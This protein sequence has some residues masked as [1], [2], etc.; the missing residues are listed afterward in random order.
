MRPPQITD[1][2]LRRK[3][4]AYLR[5]SSEDQIR[6][7]IGS[8]AIQR[9]LPLVLRGWGWPPALIEVVDT[10]LG[11]SGSIPGHREGFS[12]VL[13][14]M[15]AGLVGLVA[16]TENSRLTRNL[17]DLAAF[18]ELARRHDVLLA[19]GEAVTDFR[20]PNAAFIGA[21]L[22]ANAAREN[23]A[24]A[25]LFK[26][27]RRKKAEAG[28]AVSR[29]PVGY[30]R[31]NRLWIKDPDP[32]IQE[33]I[34]LVFDKYLELRSAGAVTRF[35]RLH[36]ILLPTRLRREGRTWVP[37][38][39]TPI[40][41]ILTHP[42]YSGAYTYGVT[43]EVPAAPGRKARWRHIWRGECPQIRVANCHE[44][45]IQP[46]VWEQIQEQLAASR[47]SLSSPAGRGEALLPGL[48][49]C[50][51]HQWALRTTYHNRVRCPDG[52]IKRVPS[53][54]CYT[55]FQTTGVSETCGKMRARRIDALVEAQILE[56]LVP[57]SVGVLEH[58]RREAMRE[59][60][61]RR[62]AREDDI[63]RAEQAVDEAE[64][65]FDQVRASQV[66]LK[67]RLGERL[68]AAL[69][70]LTD[71]RASQQARPLHPPLTLDETELAELR[72]L[73]EDLGTLWQ[74]P[75]VTFQ[76]RR[77]VV[78]LIIKAVYVT[79][80]RDR[81]T[82]EIDWVGGARTRLALMTREGVRSELRRLCAQPLSIPEITE[83]LAKKGI[84]K[85]WGPGSGQ[86]Y[87]VRMVRSFIARR[88]RGR[89]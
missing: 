41:L 74:H 51:R 53:Y 67:K 56:T 43:K 65:A 22:G 8:T 33:V 68:D 7:N 87:T 27:A 49:R 46:A 79:P 36:G 31:Q 45:Y 5:Q 16:V 13:E 3:A 75:S 77:A 55:K 86:P 15:R 54:E 64:R 47:S 63:R 23:R 32:R 84:V 69:Q 42:A 59:Y 60:D 34:Q 10:D 37:A 28:I 14:Q 6:E 73:L 30:V 50:T 88:A 12:Y 81:W 83:R 78:R 58:A 4:I 70:R 52:T 66:H 29:P 18:D 17:Q 40:F 25:L 11:V 72:G 35:F 89:A 20:D 44:P 57:P 48:V 21:I 26:L 9:D 19:V 61:L 80:D 38:Q 24:R 1:G 2:H 62:R 39:R 76:Q 85:A 71:L 82:V